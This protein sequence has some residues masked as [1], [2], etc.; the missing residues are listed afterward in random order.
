[1]STFLPL[2]AKVQQGGGLVSSLATR[3]LATTAA[4]RAE[5]HY[6][7]IVV[8]GGSGGCGTANKFASRVG[9]GKLAVIDPATTHYYQPMWTLVGGGLKTLAQSARPSES[10]LP[11]GANWIREPVVSFQPEE[12]RLVVAGGDV[13]HYDFLVVA[14]GLQL[15]YDKIKGLPEAFETP[16]VCS[17]YSPLYVEKTTKAIQDF[18]GGNAVFT[19]PTGSIKCPGAPQKIMY[20]AEESFRMRGIPANVH[21][22]TTLPVIFGVKKYA[23]ALTEI[24]NELGINLHLRQNLIEVIPDKKMAVFQHM[25]TGAKVEQPYDMI[26]VTPPMNT[27]PVLGENKDLADQAGF[28]NVNPQTLQHVKYSNVFGIG[29]CTNSPNSKT[30]AAVAGQLGIMRKNLGAAMAGKALPALYDGYTS[31]PLVTGRNKVILAEFDFQS[32]PQPLETFP[33]NQ[34]KQ[35]WSMYQMKAHVMPPLYFYGLV[36][37]WWEGPAIIRKALRLGMSR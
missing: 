20:L 1:M 31:C 21:Y 19:F 28:L 23:A 25:D 4:T 13:V 18:K 37:G 15:R 14:L 10:L 8:G 3:G 2:A 17:N 16:G 35:R 30:A 11:S 29:D 33:I 12:N 36:K 27:P 34:A 6:R 22:Y 32:P 5:H 26:H 9:K 7:L 24:V